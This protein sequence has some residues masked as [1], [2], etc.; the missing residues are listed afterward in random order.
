MPLSRFT[1]K[2]LVPLMLFSLQTLPYRSPCCCFYPKH[3]SSNLYTCRT[4]RCSVLHLAEQS[5][6]EELTLIAGEKWSARSA[7]HW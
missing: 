5:M 1:W 2:I 3:G 6:A 4:S 7:S